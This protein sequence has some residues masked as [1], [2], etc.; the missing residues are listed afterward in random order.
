MKV[1]HAGTVCR[2]EGLSRWGGRNRGSVPVW[3]H[4][5]LASPFR[6]LSWASAKG[7]P[8]TYP[9][10][11]QATHPPGS[12]LQPLYLALGGVPAC[13]CLLCSTF[14]LPPPHPIPCFPPDPRS[15]RIPVW[16]QE[17]PRHVP[18]SGLHI[19][20]WLFRTPGW[21]E[22]QGGVSCAAGQGQQEN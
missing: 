7:S 3:P 8:C 20:G 5:P 17:R 1:V 6:L 14:P 13:L 16:S 12:P 11:Q 21:F 22:P 19:P 9:G 15:I 2:G 18:F 4:I 10:T